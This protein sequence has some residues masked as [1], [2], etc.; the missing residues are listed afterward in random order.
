MKRS[1][2]QR[3]RSRRI[4]KTTYW[5]GIRFDSLIECERYKELRLLESAQQ[6]EGLEPHKEF[7]LHAPG[8][9]QIGSYTCDA[10]YYDIKN[11]TW[12]VE[13]TKG[14]WSRGL[15]DL[16]SWKWRHM[17]HEY[18]EYFYNIHKVK[19]ASKRRAA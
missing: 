11:R 5:D 6:I 8:G 10:F 13:D 1:G 16:F 19:S 9:Q 12:V 15:T 2:F 7:W 18:P 3:R 4:S 14:D 17:K